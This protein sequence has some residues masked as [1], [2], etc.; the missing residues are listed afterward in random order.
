MKTTLKQGKTRNFPYFICQALILLIFACSR[1][2]R[3]QEFQGRDGVVQAYRD[4]ERGFKQKDTLLLAAAFAS[5]EVQLNAYI[6]DPRGLR[7]NIFPVKDLISF[8]GAL[9]VEYFLEISNIQVEGDKNVAYSVADFG[10]FYEGEMLSSG[11]DLFL[12]SKIDSHWQIVSSNN[13]ANVVFSDTII[14]DP[15]SPGD[16]I[17]A[18]KLI[19]D[20]FLLLASKDTLALRQ[21]LKKPSPALSALRTSPNEPNAGIVSIDA[22]ML[23]VVSLDRSLTEQGRNVRYVDGNLALVS[24]ETS[25]G[26]FYMSLF[27]D[28]TG[29]KVTAFIGGE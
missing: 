27:S 28:T 11:Q 7:I 4:F 13:T 18:E 10:E 16:P 2:E 9:E 23:D 15:F 19:E 29:W 17:L 25:K 14:T 6:R 24:L 22:F 8:L 12:Y 5:P 26:L 20:W 1:P 21:L 3:S